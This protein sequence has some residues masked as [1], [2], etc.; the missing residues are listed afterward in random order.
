[1]CFSGPQILVFQRNP[2]KIRDKVK[3]DD[4]C[5]IQGMDFGCVY[6][7]IENDKGMISK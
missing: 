7:K 4:H 6:C 2:R 5:A 3:G 1:M